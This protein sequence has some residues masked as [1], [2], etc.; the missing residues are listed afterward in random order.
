ML[1]G[2]GD[3]KKGGQHFDHCKNT[4]VCAKVHIFGILII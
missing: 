1:M 3:L 4:Y 2:G